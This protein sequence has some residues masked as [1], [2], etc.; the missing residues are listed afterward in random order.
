M[1]RIYLETRF[2]AENQPA[3][4]PVEFAIITGYAT[5]GETW[6]DEENRAADDALR[7]ELEEMD[8]AVSRITGYSPTTLH[9]EPG[10]AAVLPWKT[11]CDV[12]ARYRQDAI[13]YVTNDD[14]WVTYCDERQQLQRV[15]PFRERVSRMT[16]DKGSKPATLRGSADGSAT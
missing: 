2:L 7:Q 8:G 9:Q 16:R 11:A 12:G 4:W 3:D 15:G 13:Y 6:S 14:L 10:W 5:T 1:N